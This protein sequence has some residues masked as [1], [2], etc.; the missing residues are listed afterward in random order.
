MSAKVKHEKFIFVARDPICL[1]KP[2]SL[3]SL[4]S[5]LILS[6]EKNMGE[7]FVLQI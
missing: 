1:L 7:V 4:H 3:S 2:V 6:S 5:L